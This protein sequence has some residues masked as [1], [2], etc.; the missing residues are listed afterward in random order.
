MFDVYGFGRTLS[1]IF[2]GS[3]VPPTPEGYLSSPLFDIMDHIIFLINM[4]LKV[5]PDDRPGFGELTAFLGALRGLLKEDNF[6]EEMV[7]EYEDDSV[8][9]WD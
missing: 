7:P 9:I 6:E 3:I 5:D 4:C 1:Y 8:D 2:F